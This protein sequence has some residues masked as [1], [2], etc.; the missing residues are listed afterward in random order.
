[1]TKK[2]F[3]LTNLLHNLIREHGTYHD[4]S[5]AVDVLTFPLSDKDYSSRRFESPRWYRYMPVDH[6]LILKRYLMSASIRA[7]GVVDK[8]CDEVFKEDMEEMRD[9]R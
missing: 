5:Y 3:S 7:A 6:Q 9:Y 8:E 2:G 1:M 4:G